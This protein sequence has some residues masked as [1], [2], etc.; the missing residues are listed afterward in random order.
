M[1]EPKPELRVGI[2]DLLR[3]PWVQQIE[4]CIEPGVVPKHIHPTPV[5]T[6][7]AGGIV[8]EK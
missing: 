3:H 6:A 1:L 2:D 7:A 4:V 8:A 5:A